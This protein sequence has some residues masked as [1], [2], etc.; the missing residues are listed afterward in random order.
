MKVIITS[1]VLFAGRSIP[2]THSIIDELIP[3]QNVSDGSSA[4]TNERLGVTQGNV[5]IAAN[6]GVS[7]KICLYTM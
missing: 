3:M 5:F 7:A 1:I 2:E 6:L 4:P